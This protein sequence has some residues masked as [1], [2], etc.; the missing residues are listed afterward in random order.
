MCKN[1]SWYYW[2]QNLVLTQE[3]LNF[4]ERM[5]TYVTEFALSRKCRACWRLQVIFHL[6]ITQW[7]VY[8]YCRLQKARI[9]SWKISV[10]FELHT[11]NLWNFTVSEQWLL[12]A[13]NWYYLLVLHRFPS[14]F[15]HKPRM[16]ILWTTP[17]ELK[18]DLLREVEDV[19]KHEH[20][21][22]M[23]KKYAFSSFKVLES[24]FSPSQLT[25][26]IF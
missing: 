6:E 14:V 15:C 5:E 4:F 7:A 2:Y 24:P 3:H 25:K 26:C 18:T 21:I 13:S 1:Y 22:G 12:L 10:V 17:A 16:S 20:V 8:V 9:F 23:L 19:F 11:F